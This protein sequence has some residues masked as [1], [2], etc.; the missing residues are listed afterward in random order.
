MA[1]YCL[2]EDLPR[3]G[4]SAEVLGDLASEEYMGPAIA[5]ASERVDSY[6]RGGGYVLPLVAVGNDIKEA[7]AVI[8]AWTTVAAH[9]VKPDQSIDDIPLYRR[10][11]DIIRWLEQVASGT[12][13]PNV[14]DSS[15]AAT[16]GGNAITGLVSSNTQRGWQADTADSLNVGPFQGG[17]R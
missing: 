9:L 5:A 1:S 11:K 13:T 14:T 15:P 2:A 16:P 10:Y 6:L 3:F 8:A 4:I 7:A 12:V 17:R